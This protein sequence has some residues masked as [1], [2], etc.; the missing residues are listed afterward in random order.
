[1]GLFSRSAPPAAPPA[2]NPQEVMLRAIIS[3]MEDALL[4]YDQNFAVQLMNPAAERLLG[5]KQAELLG[6]TLT[7]KNAE[8][9]KLQRL[10]QIIFPTLAPTIVPRS[11]AGE[12]PQVIDTSFTDPYLEIR[13]ITTPIADGSGQV[14]GFMKIIRDRTREASLAKTKTEFIAVASHQLR[15]PITNLEWSLETIAGDPGLNG[16]LKEIA[17]G[18]V[19][20]VKLLRTIVED[21]LNITKI[22]EGR[23]GYNFKETDLAEYLEKFLENV[24]PQARRVGISVYFDKPKESLPKVQMDQQKISMV[25]QNLLDNAIRYNVANGTVTV[26]VLKQPNA[27]F[28]EVTVKDTG[29]GIPAEEAEKLF[30]KFYRASNA[31]KSAA[32]GSGL[33]LYIAKNVIMAHGGR[34]WV[35]SELNRGSVFHFT[36]PVDPSLIPPKEVPLDF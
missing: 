6:Q 18:A 26:G 8:N 1:M 29:I 21:L 22:E 24:L 3:A 16:A 33:G 15:T 23:F 9:P 25:L 20:S 13:T 4:V 27:P 17:D 2:A 5:L 7:P 19:S 36:L 30:T 12:Y 31:A 32:D 28:L 11:R 14:M 35:E 10:T 34:I